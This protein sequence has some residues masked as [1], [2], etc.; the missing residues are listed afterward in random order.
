MTS[1][2][3]RTLPVEI[4][5]EIFVLL[6]HDP[7]SFS[8]TCRL[9]H[10]ISLDPLSRARHL[11]TMY[12]REEVLSALFRRHSR[13]LSPAVLKHLLWTLDVPTSAHALAYIVNIINMKNLRRS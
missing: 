12:G 6:N 11:V 2:K 9:F 10:T 1:H 3:G 8:V 4:I 13:L 7:T 5:M